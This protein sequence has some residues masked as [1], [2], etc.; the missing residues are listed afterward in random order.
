MVSGFSLKSCLLAVLIPILWAANG[1]CRQADSSSLEWIEVYFNMPADHSVAMDENLANDEADLLQTLISRIDSANY[2]IDLAIYNLEHQEAGEA[3]AR[4]ADRG[5]RANVEQLQALSGIGPAYAERIF[6]YRLEN[7]PFRNV[8][9]L[10]NIRG[11]GPV[12]MERLR[13]Y[14]TVE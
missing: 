5:V 4:A 8:E 6:D 2:S 14:V 11:I 3:L 1:V 9:E 12:T 7:G 10:R 13:P